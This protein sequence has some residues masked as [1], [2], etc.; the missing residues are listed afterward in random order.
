MTTEIILSFDTESRRMQV[1]APL[2]KPREVAVLLSQALTAYLLEQTDNQTGLILN[3]FQK[4][5]GFVR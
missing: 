1:R 5:E 3:P 4:P 2:L